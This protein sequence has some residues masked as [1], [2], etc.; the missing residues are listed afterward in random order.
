MNWQTEGDPAGGTR[1]EAAAPENSYPKE[2]GDGSR[3]EGAAGPSPEE[4]ARL[5]SDEREPAVGEPATG[6]FTVR[7]PAGEDAA[8]QD[9]R[10]APPDEEAPEDV[11]ALYQRLSA[12]YQALVDEHQRLKESYRQLRESMLRLQAD[13]DNYRRRTR[14]E[15]GRLSQEG[16]HKVIVDILPVVDNLERA[17]KAA[18]A[19][20]H[21]HAL[22][23]G[24]AAS[25]VEGIRSGVAMVLQQLQRV[26]ESYGVQPVPG[27]GEP[28]DPRWHEAVAREEPE[29][30]SGDPD[31]PDGPL[32]VVE[33]FQK[34]Y[35][36]G[37]KLLRASMVKV[38]VDRKVQPG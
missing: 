33:E 18:E 21:A 16:A 32:V 38:G 30:G 1:R 34:G 17:L 3:P 22:K 10:E 37:D 9:G 5:R 6:D 36:A 23:E 4:P 14:E 28:F 29:E 13:F 2:A 27:V 7:E 25:A 11:A 12:D 19:E 15:A 31:P 20:S 8:A 26:L 24:Y 35:R